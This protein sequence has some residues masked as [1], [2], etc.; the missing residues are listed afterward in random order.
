MKKVWILIIIVIIVFGVGF[1]TYNL[2]IHPEQEVQQVSSEELLE[3]IDE[4]N[5]EDEI[6]KVKSGEFTRV[7]A[8][9][10]AEGEASVLETPDGPVLMF[11]NFKTANG[12]DLFLY[13]SKDNDIIEKRVVNDDVVSLGT[14][15]SMEGEQAYNLP[16]DYLEY[17]NVV[18]WCRAFGVLFSYAELD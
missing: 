7:D 6:K 5:N 2:S 10:Y 15:K 3:K 14:L 1:F 16:D 4:M 17:E 13:L 12:P 9:H 8:L 11:D 18:I